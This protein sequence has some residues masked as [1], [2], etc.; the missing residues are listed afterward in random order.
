LAILSLFRSLQNV[1]NPIKIIRGI[2]L[3]DDS[4]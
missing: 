3:C 4:S 1:N 2:H